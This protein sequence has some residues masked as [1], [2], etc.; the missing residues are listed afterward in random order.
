MVAKEVTQEAADALLRNTTTKRLG[1]Y[2]DSV[3]HLSTGRSLKVA[4]R[5]VFDAVLRVN[6]IRNEVIHNGITVSR[7]LAEEACGTVVQV[8]KFLGTL[9]GVVHGS[10]ASQQ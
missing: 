3:L 5:T 7:G 8:L 4:D 6:P 2:L 9:R 10:I 1:T